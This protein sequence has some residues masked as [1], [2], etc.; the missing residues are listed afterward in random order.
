M[1][2]IIKE[3]NI[4]VSKPNVFQ[5]VVAKQYDMNT[6]FIKATFVDFGQKI[7]IPQSSTLSVII[8]A[9]RPD[10]E[11]QG[12]D[13]VIND[14]GT[15]TVP[16]H[17][18]MLEQVGTVTCDISVIDQAEGDQKKLTTTSFTLIVEK[19]AWGGEGMTNDPQYSLLIELLNT[20]DSAAEVAEEA[21]QKSNEANAVYDRMLEATRD[22]EA[23][24]NDWQSEVDK[25]N[26][27]ITEMVAM[28]GYE[29]GV[30][31]YTYDEWTEFT[32][33][34]TDAPNDPYDMCV[35]GTI[36]TNG[37]DVSVT[38]KVAAFALGPMANVYFYA[39][40]EHLVPLDDVLIRTYEGDNLLIYIHPEWGDSGKPAIQFCNYSE[41]E[42]DGFKY[43]YIQVECT[44]PLAHP[45][46]PELSDAR[47]TTH[48]GTHDSAGAALRAVDEALATHE[49]RANEHYLHYNKEISAVT[50]DV[51]GIKND[52]WETVTSNNILNEEE[53][54][55]GYV[56]TSGSVNSTSTSLKYTKPIPVKEGDIIRTYNCDGGDDVANL[57]S[58]RFITAYEDGVVNA[59]KG[60]ENQC[61]YT[62]PAGVDS[63]VIT[64]PLYTSG[65]Y[66]GRPS[67]DMITINYEATVWEE[68]FEPRTKVKDSFITVD[69]ALNA[70]S[71]NPP[72]NKVV[73]EAIN[74]HETRLAEAEA[75]VEAL[76][77]NGGGSVDSDEIGWIT[78]KMELVTTG[79]ENLY[80]PAD[81]EFGIMFDD[82]IFQQSETY[83]YSLTPIPVS[84]G[85]VIRTYRLD[86]G[87][88]QPFAVYVITAYS[89]DGSIMSKSGARQT[90]TYTVPSGVASIVITLSR[91]YTWMITKNYEATEYV[92]HEPTDSY[93]RATTDFVGVASETQFGLVKVWTT[94]VDGETVLNISTEV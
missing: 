56:H 20:V 81:Y 53:L 64:V 75:D 59:N 72:Q 68:H 67:I 47:V 4:E 46:I 76:K 14:D 28:H 25:T 35:A 85:D 54:T 66:A 43:E 27:R 94:E 52:I 3:L 6:R 41:D 33:Y 91:H 34:D 93:Y 79:S 60:V 16:L 40:P 22:A 19:A 86:G 26:A 10:G 9:L 7:T 11:S 51:A 48:R 78:K 62:V 57:R 32:A 5:A 50:R 70:E 8:N 24:A 92:K 55:Q 63:V 30:S 38:L 23:I 17:S 2:E 61:E 29:D 65:S 45:Y 12:F 13:G 42:W 77:Q 39:I 36:K 69:E 31:T 37:I 71:T 83:K 89:A 84:E 88:L 49:N 1:V 82:G 58:C 15:V 44:Y 21:L 74:D 80:N 87:E 18:W 73:A 90:I